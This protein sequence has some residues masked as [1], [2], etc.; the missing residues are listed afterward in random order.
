MTNE[1]P[2]QSI[3][4]LAAIPYS[5]SPVSICSPHLEVSTTGAPAVQM[6]ETVLSCSQSSPISVTSASV[7]VP[8]LIPGDEAKWVKDSPCSSVVVSTITHLPHST[9]DTKFDTGDPQTI[10]STI[11]DDASDLLR[12]VSNVETDAGDDQMTADKMVPVGRLRMPRPEIQGQEADVHE[13]TLELTA[14]SNA[15]S[16]SIKVD[17]REEGVE[18][19]GL[20]EVSDNKPLSSIKVPSVSD[21]PCGSHRHT[22]E[23][24]EE[25]KNECAK[26]SDG[27]INMELSSLT[28]SIAASFDDSRTLSAQHE[29]AQ[30]EEPSE[31]DASHSQ[32]VESVSTELCSENDLLSMDLTSEKEGVV[33]N[34]S[35]GADGV[36]SS[37]KKKKRKKTKTGMYNT[38]SDLA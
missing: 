1:L 19:A 22:G 7:G 5:Q 27:V 20:D 34:T 23:K 15:P 21:F 36:Q 2:E 35:E 17:L 6:V 3:K 9:R 32:Y 8:L 26:A 25:N 10:D 33:V 38:P 18:F 13:M 30:P 14:S 37:P 12:S 29:V 16:S 28:E 31:E 24:L 4:D 11:H